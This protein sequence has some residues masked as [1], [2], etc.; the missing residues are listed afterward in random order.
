M[1]ARFSAQIL[2]TFITHQNVKTFY[3]GHTVVHSIIKPYILYPS[4]GYAIKHVF[5]NHCDAEL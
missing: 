5:D 1:L 4:K 2:L 3:F